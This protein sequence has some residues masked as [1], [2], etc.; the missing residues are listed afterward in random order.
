MIPLDGSGDERLALASAG[1][2]SLNSLSSVTS[3]VGGPR[4]EGPRQGGYTFSVIESI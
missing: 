4:L 2:I 3:W 1:T